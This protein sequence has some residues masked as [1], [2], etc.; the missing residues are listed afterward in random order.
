VHHSILSSSGIITPRLLLTLGVYVALGL[1]AWRTMDDD[2]IRLVTFVV[3]AL[4]AFRTV[5]HAVREHRNSE[6][7]RE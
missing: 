6:I 3:L 7:K 4:F 2:K 1:M 5:M